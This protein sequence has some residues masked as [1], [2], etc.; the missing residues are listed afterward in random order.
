MSKLTKKQEAFVRE[1]AID[2]N[3]TQAAIRAGYKPHAAEVQGSK[4]LSI[5][6][7]QAAL[8]SVNQQIAKK[9]ELTTDRMVIEYKSLAYSNITDFLE[10]DGTIALGKLKSLPKELTAAIESVTVID[11][12]DKKGKPTRQ[13]KIKLYSKTAALEAIGRHLGWFQKDNE[14]KPATVVNL[15]PPVT[16]IVQRDERKPIID[17]TPKE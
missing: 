14:Q 8:S 17:I 7:I 6:K 4:M 1:Y 3:A 9:H 15:Q 13:A 5:P 2:W 12:F 10:D 16:L 11:G